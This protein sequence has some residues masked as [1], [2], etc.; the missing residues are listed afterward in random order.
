M[1]F[2]VTIPLIPTGV[3]FTSGFGI[4]N[5]M[6]I[7]LL[8]ALRNAGIGTCNIAEVNGILPPECKVISSAKGLK[9]LKSGQ[10]IHGVLATMSDHEPNRLVSAAIGWA[11]TP[12]KKQHG[13]ISKHVARGKTGKKTGDAAEDS[14][15]TMLASTLGIEFDPEEAWQA[16]EK[17]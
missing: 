11:W 10:I 15:A 17:I 7:S 2:N 8:L 14:A 6:S 16:R 5:S 1:Q 9:E 12:D 3:F 4:G 13:Y